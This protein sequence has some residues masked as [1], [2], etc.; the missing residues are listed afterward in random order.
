MGTNI[1][2]GRH[3]G[4]LYVSGGMIRHAYARSMYNVSPH[5]FLDDYLSKL[6]NAVPFFIFN[7]S[8]LE[9]SV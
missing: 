7:Y 8:H 2:T 6:K 4:A 9:G 5:I 1:Y 3:T